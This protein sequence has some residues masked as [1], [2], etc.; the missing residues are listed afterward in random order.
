M[1]EFYD[2]KNMWDEI[3]VEKGIKERGE[4]ALVYVKEREAEYPGEDWCWDVFVQGEKVGSLLS[5]EAAQR[6][7]R[8]RLYE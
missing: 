4:S 1:V 5:R 7:L 8:E 2:P 6:R 3:A